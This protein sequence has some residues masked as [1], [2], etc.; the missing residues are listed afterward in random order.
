MKSVS[1]LCL[2]VCKKSTAL[3]TS[4][5]SDL[6]LNESVN[7][8]YSNKKKLILTYRTKMC[9]L[10]CLLDYDGNLWSPSVN[11]NHMQMEIQ[12]GAGQKA[13]EFT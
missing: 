7:E 9:P 10:S 13:L 3:L 1:V 4:R 12:S 5:Y 2:H 6:R 11:S 8:D